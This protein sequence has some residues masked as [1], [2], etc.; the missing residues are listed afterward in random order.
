[1]NHAEI[2]ALLPQHH[3]KHTTQGIGITLFDSK[4]SPVVRNNKEENITRLVNF[5]KNRAIGEKE[6]KHK[7][8]K[9]KKNSKLSNYKRST[10]T[11]G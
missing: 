11:K 2:L 5:I 7:H 10:L 3:K 4:D 1:M 9:K 6:Y 8:K